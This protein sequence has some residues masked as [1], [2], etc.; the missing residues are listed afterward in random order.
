MAQPLV[1]PRAGQAGHTNRLDKEKPI[2]IGLPPRSSPSRHLRSP[3][4]GSRCGFNCYPHQTSCSDWAWSS[5]GSTCPSPDRCRIGVRNP[6]LRIPVAHSRN[7]AHNR[8]IRGR[9]R[10]VPGPLE[11]RSPGAR[12]PPLAFR[13]PVRDSSPAGDHRLH[14]PAAGLPAHSPRGDRKRAPCVPCPYRSP[15][16]DRNPD[17]G[18]NPEHRFR[19][20]DRIDSP[21]R[22]CPR[23][24]PVHS[25]A[26]PTWVLRSPFRRPRP[27]QPA[28]I[29]SRSP[30][31]WP[32]S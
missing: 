1:R 24:A 9:H 25:R 23:R 30:P 14:S 3:I 21:G 13:R 16:P 8:R 22:P 17:P 11:G 19:N 27:M 12:I 10:K 26:S 29:P 7:S 20:P 2:E 4:P 32:V 18:R 5:S 28:P 15:D 6:Y 31:P